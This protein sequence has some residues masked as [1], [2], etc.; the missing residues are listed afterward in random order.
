MQPVHD[1]DDV[2]II[3]WDDWSSDLDDPVFNLQLGSSKKKWAMLEYCP[4]C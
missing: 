2:I 4:V 3:D 1:D